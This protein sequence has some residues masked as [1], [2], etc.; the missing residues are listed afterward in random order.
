MATPQETDSKLV[1][2]RH[3]TGEITVDFSGLDTEVRRI[4]EEILRENSIS[5]SDAHEIVGSSIAQKV[6]EKVEPVLQKLQI[7]LDCKEGDTNPEMIKFLFENTSLKIPR[8]KINLLLNSRVDPSKL[9]GEH[10]LFHYLTLNYRLLSHQHNDEREMTFLVG[11]YE[12]NDAWPELK[13]ILTSS[14]LNESD[15]YSL[16]CLLGYNTGPV[17]GTPKIEKSLI[18]LC[19]EAL[20]THFKENDSLPTKDEILAIKLD[21]ETKANLLKFLG[22]TEDSEE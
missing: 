15:Q 17:L 11:W 9:S 6:E 16:L 21:D 3:A 5:D 12:D 13:A 4:A 7:I 8:W 1:K 10:P 19:M 14:L 18:I 2:I 22:F 20:R